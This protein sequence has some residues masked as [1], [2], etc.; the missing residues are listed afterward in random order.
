[1][2]PSVTR[3]GT[4]YRSVAT[5]KDA[6][7]DAASWLQEGL[8]NREAIRAELAALKQRQAQLETALQLLDALPQPKA[9]VYSVQVEGTTL[10][11]MHACLVATPGLNATELR[12]ALLERGKDVTSDRI[13]TYLYRLARKGLVEARGERGAQRYYPAGGEK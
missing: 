11:W 2:A 4:H 10:D 9:S 8:R 3:S 5:T 1:M 7:L 12:R 6:A 13:H